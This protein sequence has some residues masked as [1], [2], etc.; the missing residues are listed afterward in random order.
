MAYNSRERNWLVAVDP[1]CCCRGREAE[2]RGFLCRMLPAD[3]CLAA[4]AWHG[5]VAGY[6]L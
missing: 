5:S 4:A 3:V 6:Y 2:T 1:S